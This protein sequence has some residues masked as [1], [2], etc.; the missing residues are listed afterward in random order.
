[1]RS[2]SPR[3]GGSRKACNL[4]ERPRCVVTTDVAAEPVVLD[5]VAEFV[6]RT[7]TYGAHLARSNAKYGTRYTAEEFSPRDNAL[8]CVRPQWVFGLDSADFAGSPTRWT[9]TTP[10]ACPSVATDPA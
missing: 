7:D 4:R 6:E 9:F 1:M 2:G 8:L 5:G 3:R 10:S